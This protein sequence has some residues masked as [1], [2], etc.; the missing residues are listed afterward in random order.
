[1]PSSHTKYCNWK[2]YEG[3]WYNH[4]RNLLGNIKQSITYD[5]ATPLLGTYTKEKQTPK[6]VHTYIQMLVSAMF[7]R[8][9]NSKLSKR[10]STQNTALTFSNHILYY[11]LHITCH[12]NI[13]CIYLFLSPCQKVSSVSTQIFC[14]LRSKWLNFSPIDITGWKILCHQELICTL[15]DVQ[16][17]P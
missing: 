17:Q 6:I 4:F 13:Y 2:A 10:P 16:Q 14:L 15:Q 1:M 12:H 3:N 8:A 7:T 5:H 9:Q 11:F